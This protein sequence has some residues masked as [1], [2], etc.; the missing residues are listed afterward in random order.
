MTIPSC[1]GVLIASEVVLVIPVLS[2]SRINESDSPSLA[3]IY[4][5]FSVVTELALCTKVI[6]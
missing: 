4:S 3:L 2:F 1:G 5:G 6:A